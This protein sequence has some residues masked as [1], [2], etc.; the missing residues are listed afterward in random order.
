L[1]EKVKNAIDKK[2]A[3]RKK[4]STN[5]GFDS[6]LRHLLSNSDDI[7]C[8]HES[9][10]NER[11][12]T[13]IDEYEYRV[14][15]DNIDSSKQFIIEN[16]DSNSKIEEEFANVAVDDRRDL[17][18]LLRALDYCK[19]RLKFF[20]IR[21]AVDGNNDMTYGEQKLEFLVKYSNFL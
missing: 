9:S 3:I 13:I 11:L 19:M 15:D 8:L 14:D 6:W 1:N 2:I 5:N 17:I 21:N 7:I 12:E 16:N 10:N 20:K 4:Y 18:R